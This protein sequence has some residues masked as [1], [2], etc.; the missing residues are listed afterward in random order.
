LRSLDG[1]VRNRPTDVDWRE[2]ESGE[3][4]LGL[5]TGEAVEDDRLGTAPADLQRGFPIIV[6]RALDH[7]A[8]AQLDHTVAVGGAQLDEL[9]SG[10]A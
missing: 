2:P 6:G 5:A 7:P 3:D 8:I 4:I 1:F 9:V 10:Q